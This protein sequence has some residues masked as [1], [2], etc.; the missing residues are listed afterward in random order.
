MRDRGGCKG[1]D[2]RALVVSPTTQILVA[3]KS[4]QRDVNRA[5]RRL[6]RIEEAVGSSG[7]EA[8][9]R[10]SRKVKAQQKQNQDAIT[11]NTTT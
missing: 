7:K 11:R 8:I 3:I 2:A 10:V 5:N 6:G 4:L 9:G 1:R